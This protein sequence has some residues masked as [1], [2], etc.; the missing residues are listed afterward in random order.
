MIEY[1]GS[2]NELSFAQRWSHYLTLTISALGII[3]A[4]NLQNQT[5]N[6]VVPYTNVQ[7]GISAFYPA[8][9]LLDTRGE[10]VF[11]VRDMSQPEFNTTI[12][13]SV[14]PVS[15]D[16]TERNVLDSLSLNRSQTLTDYTI[17][18][19]EDFNLPDE[20]IGRS[21]RYVYVFRD[22]SPFLES[23]PVV[24]SGIDIL[25][26]QRG[27]AI[28]ISFRADADNFD[29]QFSLFESFLNTLNF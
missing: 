26:I 23:I 29:S 10:Y 16:T 7:A 27:Q 17:L 20:T 28:I 3:Y 14:R 11:R 12:Q 8:D 18:T 22:P 4:L 19:T 9:W 2:N 1:L 24:V 13:V 15:E 6:A 25:T 21:M 5:L